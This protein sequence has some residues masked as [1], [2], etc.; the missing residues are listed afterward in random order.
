MFSA[1]SVQMAARRIA[2]RMGCDAKLLGE[3]VAVHVQ[4]FGGV[5]RK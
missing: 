5:V 3:G 1:K 2:R 4:Y